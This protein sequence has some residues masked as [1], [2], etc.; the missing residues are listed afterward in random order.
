MVS[1]SGGVNDIFESGET[2]QFIIQD[3][4][5]LNDTSAAIFVS[6]GVGSPSSLGLE[7][8]HSSGSI[9]AFIPEPS[10]ALLLA[11]GLVA[12]AMRRRKL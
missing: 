1:E 2:W 3:Y 9:I 11:L 12:L 6:P 5:N 4:S 8:G 7:G 10:T